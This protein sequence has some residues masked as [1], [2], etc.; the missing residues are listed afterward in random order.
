MNKLQF[1]GSYVLEQLDGELLTTKAKLDLMEEA[2]GVMVVAKVANTLQGKVTF[3]DGKLSGGLTSTTRT[4][5]DE[6]SMIERALLKGFGA[7]LDVQ[8]SHD[9]LTLAGELNNLVFHRVLTV[10]SLVGRYAFREFNGKPVEAGDMEL[11]VIPSNEEC[12]SVVAQFTNTLR[13]ELK[14]EDDILQ[15]VIASTTLD[16][17]GVQK[18]MEGRF[19]AGMDGGMRVFVDGRTLTLKDDHSVFLYLRSLLPSDVAG[20]YMFKTLNG[21]PVR[22]DGQARLVLSQGRGGGV[23]VVA[24][25]VNI[26]SGRVQM[27]ED[28]LRGELMAT[29]MLGSE[30]EMLLESALTSGFSAGF[31]CTLDEGRLTM[32]CGENT[33][34]YAKAVAMPYLNGKPTYLGESVVPCFKG[35]GNGLMFRIVNADERKWAFYNDTTG[36]NMRVVVTFGLR[37]RVEGLSD[38]FLTVNEDGQQVAEALVA[39]GA[40]VM[41]IAGHVNGYRCSYDAEPL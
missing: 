8:W 11:V 36:Y 31:L 14:L 17:E 22:L 10:E 6:Q 5:T 9:T 21:A 19:Y 16:S 18:E 41:F 33:L 38:T 15:G 12:V 2:D 27:A 39:P 35:H 1:C 34:V 28:T 29:T 24:K 4:G 25:V 7:G 30:A 40:T 3:N 13:G 26:L 23:D 20:E 37:S 32:R